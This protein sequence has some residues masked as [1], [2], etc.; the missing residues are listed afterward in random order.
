MSVIAV[1]YSFLAATVL[2]G[3]LA[4]LSIQPELRGWRNLAILASLLQGVL[5]PFIAGWL[6]ALIVWSVCA[7]VAAVAYHLYEFRAA[8]RHPLEE[9]ADPEPGQS[10]AVTFMHALFLWPLLVF[11]TFENTCAELFPAMMSVSE[12]GADDTEW[13]ATLDSKQGGIE[14]A[15][16]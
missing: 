4:S 8:R 9:G 11:D 6:T 13:D 7:L 15:S 3:C 12:P 10:I 1:L 2:V 16:D 14:D 5:S